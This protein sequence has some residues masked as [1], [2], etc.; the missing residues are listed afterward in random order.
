MAGRSYGPG[1]DFWYVCT[2]TLTLEVWPKIKVMT[3]PS[4]MDKIV[5]NIIQIQLGSEELWPGHRFPVCVH[6]DIDL[7]DMTLGQ[8]LCGGGG[9]KVMTHPWVMD[10]NCVKYYLDPTR[11][12][13]VMA[14]TRVLGKCAL[15][16]WP[17]IYDLWSR[18]WHD[19][20]SWTRLCEIS[21]SDKGVRNYGPHTMWTDRWTNVR[22]D[23]QGDSYKMYILPQTLFAEGIKILTHNEAWTHI[24][25]IC[26][27]VLYW[28]GYLGFDESCSI[29][30]TYL[31]TC[32][33]YQCI[34]W[35]IYKF[36]NDEVEHILSCTCTVCC[37]ILEYIYMYWCI[38]D[39]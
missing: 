15:R 20:G 5:R 6:C 12:W 36:E 33:G 16:P 21:G 19:L 7:G 10:N 13:E 25:E 8:G 4:V 9:I 34:H 39:K 26:S 31:H 35:Y 30:M 38:L 27:V 17:W 37:Y 14:Q 1:T 11:Q 18:S 24:L 23:R 2:L 28:L 3:H 22:M 29:K 32:T